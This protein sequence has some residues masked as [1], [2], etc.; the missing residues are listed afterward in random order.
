[1]TASPGTT[2]TPYQRCV[3]S[4]PASR[5]LRLWF[6]LI[7]SF[8]FVGCFCAVFFVLVH[9]VA[10]SVGWSISCPT[11][12]CI[13]IET[14]KLILSVRFR[15]RTPAVRKRGGGFRPTAYVQD[16]VIAAAQ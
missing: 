9:E 13:G 14:V 5:D 8:I 12:M 15:G 6:L 3:C 16:Q 7:L 11:I 4:C 10:F 1:M 2:D